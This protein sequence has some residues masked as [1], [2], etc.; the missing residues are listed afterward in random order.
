[1]KKIAV[2]ALAACAAAQLVAAPRVRAAA[3]ASAPVQDDEDLFSGKVTIEQMS[4]TGRGSMFAAPSGANGQSGIGRCYTKP[5]YWIVLEAKYQTMARCQERLT[6]TWHV[7]LESKTASENK[8]NRDKLPQYSY[9]T[10]T[11]T[12]VNIPRGRHAASACLH[13][14]FAERYGEPKAIGVVFTNAKGEVVAAQCESQIQGIKSFTGADAVQTAFW[15][16]ANVMDAKDKDGET[17][18]IERRE[19]LLDRSRTIWAMVNS[20]DYELVAQ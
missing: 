8:G 3:A 7:L 12:Y 16:D 2:L 18:M 9:L 19:G 6:C 1:M 10:T 14:S 11:A 13:P 5:R 15:N 4:K 17:P 20:D